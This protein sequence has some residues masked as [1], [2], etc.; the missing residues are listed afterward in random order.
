ME[1]LQDV[2]GGMIQKA[3]QHKSFIGLK[4]WRSGRAVIRASLSVALELEAASCLIPTQSLRF[5]GR[6]RTRM[7]LAVRIIPFPGVVLMLAGCSGYGQAPPSEPGPEAVADA[8]L[9]EPRAATGFYSVAQAERGLRVFGN[10]CS[11]CHFTN[12]FRGDEFEHEWRRKTVWD[13][14]RSMTRT[15]PEND[16]GGLPD[17]TYA[18]VIEYILQ[19]NKY[20]SGTVEL[21]PERATMD[22]IPLGPGAAKQ[23][24][25]GEI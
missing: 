4:L 24:A 16:P 6:F 19:I 23:R 3:R 25:Q 2:W 7:Q 15:M 18:D 13:L 1:S 5:G 12:E 20:A 11:E 22:S 10:L 14:Y 17:R 9:D 21:V 8:V